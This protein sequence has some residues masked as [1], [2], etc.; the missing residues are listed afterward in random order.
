MNL[1]EKQQRIILNIKMLDSLLEVYNEI[2]G[3][4]DAPI[5]SMSY[6]QSSEPF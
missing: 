3:S 4:M 5:V 6:F 1:I 2:V